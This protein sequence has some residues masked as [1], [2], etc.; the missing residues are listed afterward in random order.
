MKNRKKKK[1]LPISGLRYQYGFYR[2]LQDNKE[3]NNKIKKETG[4]NF[5]FEFL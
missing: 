1:K 3:N 5:K 2:Y 4:D